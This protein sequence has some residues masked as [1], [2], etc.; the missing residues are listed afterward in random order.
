[1]KASIPFSDFRTATAGEPSAYVE[2]APVEISRL[3]D[4]EIDPDYGKPGHK[5]HWAP[6]SGFKVP[7]LGSC[8]P[9]ASA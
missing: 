9:T 1:M 7:G 4:G 5:G 2:R 6:D 8:I 3:T